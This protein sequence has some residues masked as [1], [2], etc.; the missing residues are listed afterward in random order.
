MTVAVEL[1][2]SS[3]RA[4]KKEG[5]TAADGVVAVK[6]AADNSYAVAI[7]VNSETDFVVVLCK[8]DVEIKTNKQPERKKE[9]NYQQQRRRPCQQ[10]PQGW[11]CTPKG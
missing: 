6:V 2:I 5:R 9:I 10:L 1:A 7:E 8:S 3:V 11:H 4:A